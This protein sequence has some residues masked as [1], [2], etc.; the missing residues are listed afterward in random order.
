MEAIKHLKIEVERCEGS[1][2]VAWVTC[3][4]CGQAS[5]SKKLKLVRDLPRSWPVYNLDCHFRRHLI[6]NDDKEDR[7]K[8]K[9]RRTVPVLQTNPSVF[10]DV[11]DAGRIPVEK[12]NAALPADPETLELEGSPQSSS[13]DF[14]DSSLSSSTVSFYEPR[15]QTT[16]SAYEEEGTSSTMGNL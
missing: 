14:L 8:R 3:P 1:K 13:I 16:L 7:P 11:I 10:P 5:G 6:Q 2:Q 9:R 12:V 15:H 4:M